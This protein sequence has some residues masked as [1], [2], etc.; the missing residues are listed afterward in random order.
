VPEWNGFRSK[1]LISHLQ[2]WEDLNTPR[3]RSCVMV[4]AVKWG[5]ALFCVA[6]LTGCSSHREFRVASVGPDGSFE[7]AGDEDGSSATASGQTTS[8][9]GVVAS[10]GNAGLGGGQPT[11]GTHANIGGTNGFDVGVVTPLATVGARSGS[12]SGG[13]L[14]QVGLGSPTAGSGSSAVL[15]IGAGPLISQPS[16]SGS[17]TGTVT[18]TVTGTLNSALGQTCC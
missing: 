2:R 6:A 9:Q 8:R 5:M 11:A 4:A 10:S 17:L 18:T 16:S 3:R 13:G 12:Q 7:I 15:G 1:W 14:V